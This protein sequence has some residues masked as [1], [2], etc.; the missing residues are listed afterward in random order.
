M[1][2]TLVPV[3]GRRFVDAGPVGTSAGHEGGRLSGEIAATVADSRSDPAACCGA[4]RRGAGR[5]D[6]Y[7]R[8]LEHAVFQGASGHHSH[9]RCLDLPS[10]GL[11]GSGWRRPPPARAPPGRLRRRRRCRPWRRCAAPP[12]PSAERWSGAGVIS[13]CRKSRT[14]RVT[15]VWSCVAV[16]WSRTSAA[17]ARAEARRQ[18]GMWRGRCST[19][20]PIRGTAGGRAHAC[21][22]RR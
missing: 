3:P 21:F 11:G 2:D 5:A 22:A 16:P 9:P 17:A 12:D 14:A 10:R 13:S 15:S 1:L 4:P 8:P 7:A 20:S 18:P 19:R 6:P